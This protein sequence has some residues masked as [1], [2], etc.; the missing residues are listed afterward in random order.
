MSFWCLQFSQKN[1]LENSNFCPSLLGEKFFVCFLGKL[2]KTKCSFENYWPLGKTCQLSFSLWNWKSFHSCHFTQLNIWNWPNFSTS[3]TARLDI[4]SFCCPTNH[5][6]LRIKAFNQMWKARPK[7]STSSYQ[8]G[9]D[10][11][12]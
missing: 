10:L 5:S 8:R 7:I 6:M 3:S 11:R 2:K 4:I 1:K 9:L 12:L